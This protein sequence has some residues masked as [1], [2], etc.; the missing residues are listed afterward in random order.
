MI[1]PLEIYTVKYAEHRLA[2]ITAR[3]IGETI[4]RSWL[5]PSAKAEDVVLDEWAELHD[6]LLGFPP[7]W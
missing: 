3:R 4:S 5:L 7:N 6:A 2:K 1:P